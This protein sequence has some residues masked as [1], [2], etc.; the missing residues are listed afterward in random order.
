[1]AK[2]I[3]VGLRKGGVGKTTSV[4]NIGA[5]LAKD[6]KKRVLLVDM[7]PQGHIAL[8]FGIKPRKLPKT[9]Y[10]VFTG[11]STVDDILPKTDYNVDILPANNSLAQFDMLVIDNRDVKNPALW[12]KEI[13]GSLQIRYDYIILDLPPALNWL[14]VNALAATNELI[15]PMQAELFAES[16]VSDLL[17]SVVDVRKTLNP[18]LKISGILLTMFNARTNLSMIVSQDIRKFADLQGIRIF[19]TAISRSVR[20]GEANLMGKPA[21]IYAPRNDAIKTYVEF[22]RELLGNG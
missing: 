3:A 16:G 4:V 22:T 21:V 2:V 12:L 14:T 19:N 5:V 9:L 18:G 15:I 10:D 7:D 1:M 8:S 17:E 6:H 13:L 11:D 20:F